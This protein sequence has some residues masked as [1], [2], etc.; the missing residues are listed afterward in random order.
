MAEAMFRAAAPHIRVESAGAFAVPGRN[1]D[2]RAARVATE[3]GFSLEHH[4]ARPFSQ[5]MIDAAD[6]LVVMDYVNYIVLTERFPQ[7]AGKTILFGSL[8]R[9]APLQIDDPYE[10][11]LDDVRRAFKRI[12]TCSER[13]VEATHSTRLD[14]TAPTMGASTSAA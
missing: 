14:R 12:Q 6:L 11:T 10:G 13:L 3:F 5:E 1:A 8:E 2:T 7:A 9:G 4:H